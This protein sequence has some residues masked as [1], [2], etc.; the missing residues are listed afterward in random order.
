MAENEFNISNRINILDG[1]RGLA[2]I[3]VVVYHFLY[4][5]QLVFNLSMPFFDSL[6]MDI[7]HAGFI[8]ILIGVSGICTAF[9]RNVL[10]RGVMLFFV[11]EIITIVTS[12]LMP[13]EVIIFGVI[14]FFGIVMM[15]Y[16][17]LKPFLDKIPWR[18]LFIV[19]VM[20]YI[21]FYRFDDSIVLWLKLNLPTD[22]QHL[23]PLGITFKGFSSSDYF[24]LIPNA[25]V[26]LA[27]VALSKPVSERKLPKS[28]YTVKTPA[29]DFIGRN[30]LIIYIV[31]QPIIVGAMMLTKLMLGN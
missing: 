24:P 8:I 30:S 11:G 4:D 19:S 13:D 10:K 7:I 2:M 21:V 28:F 16:F 5:L 14:S 26:F 23:Y 31:H 22:N 1:L 17:M 9:S 18:V 12:I 6:G 27:G 29:V 3:F 15:L 20:L 25:F